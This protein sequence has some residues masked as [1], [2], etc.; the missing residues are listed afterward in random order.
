MNR[1][2]TKAIILT[3]MLVASV[4]MPTTQTRA[5][6]P[7]DGAWSVVVMTTAGSCDA[8]FRFSGQIVNGEISY[9]YNTLEVTGRVVASGAAWVRVKRG[10]D[11][12]E[13]HGKLT[14]THGSGTWSGQGPQGRCAG[15]WTATR[16]SRM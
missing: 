4:F 16:A 14:P 12:G 1:N 10:T 9:A 8:S 3:A 15:T 5:G 6:T 2:S 7:F 13:A 11:H